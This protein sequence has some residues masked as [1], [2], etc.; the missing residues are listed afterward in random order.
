M[1]DKRVSVDDVVGELRSGMTIGI[2]GWG[3]RRKPMAVVRAICRSDLT[4]LTLVAYGGPDV[5]LLCATGKVRKVVCGFV[6]LD[7]IPLDPHWRAARQ[8]GRVEVMEVDEGMFFLGLQAA[9]WRVPFLP[10]RAGLGSD[11]LT[12]NPDLRLV[13][14]PYG[15]ASP[16]L[17]DPADADVELVAMPALRLDAAVVHTNRADAAGN[18]QILSP[19]PFFDA[20]FLGAAERRFITTEQV[21]ANGMLACEAEPLLTVSIHRMLTDGVAETPVARTSRP[22]RPTTGATSRSRRSTPPRRPTRRA[23]RPSPTATSSSARTSTRRA[24]RS[25]GTRERHDGGTGTGDTG[26]TRAEFCVVACADTWRGDGRDNGQPVRDRP[27]PRGTSGQAHLRHGSRAHRWR[28]RLDGGRPPDLDPAG[29]AGARGGHALPRCVRRRVVGPAPHHDDGQPDRP[30]GQS[31]HLG[32]WTARQAEG[33]TGRRPRCARET[34]STTR[35]VTGSRTTAPAPSSNRSTLSAVWATPRA[36]AAGMGA[37]RFHD[38]RRVVSNLGVFDFE[39]P[40]R[41][42]RLCSHHPGVSVADLAAATGFALTIPPDVGETRLPTPEELELIRV[43]LDPDSL[44]DREVR[45]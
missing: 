13:R 18:G 28:S 31:E 23:G 17:A 37:T 27:V 29:R 34:R 15:T 44:R 22:I 10:T 35:R 32:R 39:T 26:V 30:L 21:V 14:S 25:G 1:S 2:G 33:A 11:V 38:V 3:S 24:S 20:L 6:T 40:D 9:A 36:A 42:M 45:T 8:H 19:D 5:G 7:S 12:V 4:D 41:T 43:V 16:L